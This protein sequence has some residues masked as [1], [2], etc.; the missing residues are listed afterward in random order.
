MSSTVP[1]QDSSET[2]IAGQGP[3]L[4]LL[5]EISANLKE[6]NLTLKDHTT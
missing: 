5:A 4:A 3:V 6:L 1:F 2:V